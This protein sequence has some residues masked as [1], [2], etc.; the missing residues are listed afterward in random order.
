LTRKAEV[1]TDI[2]NIVGFFSVFQG[3]VLT[4][5]SQLQSDTYSTCGVIPFPIILSCLG[6]L[7]GIAALS[8]KFASLRELELDISVDRNSLRVS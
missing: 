8:S 7:V 2:F 3:V 1:N 4:A 5:V 6:A